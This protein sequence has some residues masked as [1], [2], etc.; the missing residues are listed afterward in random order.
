[1]PTVTKIHSSINSR[2]VHRG[3]HQRMLKAVQTQRLW[4]RIQG[5]GGRVG[6]LLC[7]NMTLEHGNKMLLCIGPQGTPD[8]GY[9]SSEFGS[10]NIAILQYDRRD[11]ILQLKHV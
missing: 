2:T 3:Q 9:I 5:Y 4:R 7:R 8:I 10:Q 1:M 11:G 6:H